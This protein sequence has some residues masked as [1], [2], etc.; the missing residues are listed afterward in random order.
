MKNETKEISYK[1]V[2]KQKE[3][4]KLILASLISRFGD[5]VDSL[6]FTWLVYQVTGSAAWSAIVFA[7]NQLPEILVQPF[8]GALVEGLNKKRLMIITHLI[9]GGIVALLALLTLADMVTPFILVLFTFLITTVEAFCLPAGMAIVPKLLTEEYYEYG[10]SLKASLGSVVELI[11]MALGGV[12]IGV[13][14]IYTAIFIDAVTFF[15]A[16]LILSF[17][18]VKEENLQ[19][20]SGDIKG[21]IENLKNGIDYVKKQPVI[22]NFCLMGILLNALLVPF[23]SLQGPIVSEL[24]GQDAE[25]LSVLGIALVLAM[26]VGSAIFPSLSK[27]VSVR[28][29]LVGGGF[30]IGGGLYV[31]TLGKLC[32]DNIFVIYGIAI[33]S[34]GLLGIGVGIFTSALN[35]QFMKVVNK[36]YMARAGSIFN[37]TATA[38]APVASLLVSAL[39]VRF[40]VGEILVVCAVFCAI[41]FAYIAIRKVRF[42]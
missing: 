31:L 42:E 6:A 15:G 14:G 28:G 32:V 29:M 19:R 39:A 1:D 38:A 4:L 12:I 18:K 27:R 11:G 20:G 2:L 34:S 13:W 40:S 7:V 36:E 9:R 5:S 35:V 16:A 25:F 33:V 30:C 8:A 10:T 3:Y 37:A 24:L 26:S 23:N 21:Y 17:M 22:W 41:M